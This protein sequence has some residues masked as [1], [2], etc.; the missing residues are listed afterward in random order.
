ML[1]NIYS[2][3]DS[4]VSVYHRPFHAHN[5]ESMRRECLRILDNRDHDITRNPEDFSVFLL[6]TF[7][8]QNAQFTLLPSPLSLI[9][10]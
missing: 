4:K 8:D 10:I 7:D 2:I 6:G 1:T 3:F 5:E 9:H